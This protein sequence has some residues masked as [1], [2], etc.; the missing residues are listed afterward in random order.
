MEDKM[1]VKKKYLKSKPVCKVTFRL[2]KKSVGQARKVCVVGDFN[3]WNKEATP[4]KGLKSGDFTTTIDLNVD[5]EVQFRYLID[6]T[7]WENDA[8]AD[9][10]TPNPFGDGDNCVLVL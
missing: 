3:G 1:S 9:R 4:M 7:V 2:D 6:E 8:A 10:F 5:Q